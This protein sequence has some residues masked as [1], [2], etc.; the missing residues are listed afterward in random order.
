[1]NA[2]RW[3]D[4]AACRTADDPDLWHPIGTTGPALLQTAQAK[5]MCARCPV[6][7][8]CLEAAMNAEGGQARDGRHG[9]H[10]GLTGGERH[11]LYQRRARQARR[12]TA[13]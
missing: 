5:A 7:H 3:R 12:E 6:R 9:I 2:T 8:D 11:A 1:M 10:G 13:A 4:L